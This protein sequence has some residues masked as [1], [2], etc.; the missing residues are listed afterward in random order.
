[1]RSG[2]GER[3]VADVPAS[4]GGVPA[5]RERDT[6]GVFSDSPAGD[7]PRG[8]WPGLGQVAAGKGTRNP[9]G[10]VGIVFCL[11]HVRRTRK[12]TYRAVANGAYNE[13]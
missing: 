6:R 7:G 4:G 11:G 9:S 3:A 8:R 13:L 12:E 5:L 10:W 1:M 2:D